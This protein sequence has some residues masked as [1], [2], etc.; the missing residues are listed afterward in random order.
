MDIN[1]WYFMTSKVIINT[2]YPY[3]MRVSND[4]GK[5]FGPVLILSDKR[6]IGTGARFNLLFLTL[7]VRSQQYKTHWATSRYSSSPVSS[8][9]VFPLSSFIRYYRLIALELSGKE[10]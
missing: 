5:T 8:S 9:P 4:N 3:T 6:P 10:K 1:D 2:I 7:Q